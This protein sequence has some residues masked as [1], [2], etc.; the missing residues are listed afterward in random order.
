MLPFCAQ[1]IV[2]KISRCQNK[3]QKKTGD[4]PGRLSPEFC[5]LPCKTKGGAIF[6]DYITTITNSHFEGNNATNNG[7]AV[8]ADYRA[9]EQG[10]KGPH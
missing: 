3:T 2:I 5:L 6:A 7:G 9:G 10:R 1:R 8:I 4:S